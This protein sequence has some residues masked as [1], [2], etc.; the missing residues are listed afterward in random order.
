MRCL[1]FSYI[2]LGPAFTFEGLETSDFSW[3]GSSS[4]HREG[5]KGMIHHPH[6]GLGST[7]APAVSRQAQGCPLGGDHRRQEPHRA[8]RPEGRRWSSPRAA[9]DA[10]AKAAGPVARSLAAAVPSAVSFLPRTPARARRPGRTV[11][12]AAEPHHA[13][14]IWRSPAERRNYHPPA[15]AHPAREEHRRQPLPGSGPGT[16]ASGEQPRTCNRRAARSHRGSRPIRWRSRPVTV[17][18]RGAIFFGQR[19]ESHH[20]SFVPHGTRVGTEIRP[21]R[22]PARR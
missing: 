9:G 5:L 16:G 20:R 8:L 18:Q 7:R 19:R 14:L 15:A 21:G 17:R 10:P 6:A 11:S 22:F 13:G 12:V 1:E 3:Y 4:Q 2:N